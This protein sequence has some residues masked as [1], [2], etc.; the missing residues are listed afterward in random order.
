MK[1]QI[2]REQHYQNQTKRYSG[3]YQQ[4]GR[5]LTDADWNELVDILKGEVRNVLQDIIG[6]GIPAEGGARVELIS[7]SSGSVNIEIKPGKVYA[8]GW[9]AEIRNRNDPTSQ[10]KFSYAEQAD[11]LDPPSPDDSWINCVLYA[12]IWDRVV[13]SLEDPDLPDPGLNGADTCFRTQRMAQVKWFKTGQ[14]TIE[15]IPQK[16][17]AKLTL[18]LREA[19]I[20]PDPCEPCL[21]KLKI[22][23]ELGN[24][25]FRVEIASVEG[26]ADKPTAITFKWSSEN[27]AEQYLFDENHQPPAEFTSG[28]WLW[29]F[30]NKITER[31]PGVHPGNKPTAK[32]EYSP[33][34]PATPLF[35]NNHYVRR[36]DG[37]CL[38]EKN[39]SDEWVLKKDS[40][41]N[42]VIGFDKGSPLSTEAD[43]NANGYVLIDNNK[44]TI[45]INLQNIK[46]TLELGGKKVVAG[47]YWLAP[48]RWNDITSEGDNSGKL[49]LDS[50]EPQGILHHYVKLAEIN[51]VGGLVQF[52][53]AETRRNHFPALTNLMASDIGFFN[54]CK[55]SDMYHNSQNVQEALDSLCEIEAYNIKYRP[56]CHETHLNV[57]NVREA[58][59]IILCGNNE[60]SDL[61]LVGAVVPFAISSD[62]I[63]KQFER[64]EFE[65]LMGMIDDDTDKGIVAEA[66]EH[67]HIYYILRN[68]GCPHK[69]HV[70]R[71]INKY[72]Y[73]LPKGWLRCDGSEV[74]RKHFKRMFDKIGETFG[75]GNRD[76]T[77]NIPDLRRKFIRGWD[78]KSNEQWCSQHRPY[79][80][81]QLNT[82]N[83]VYSIID[84]VYC[85][86]Y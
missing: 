57:N 23:S 46:L 11:F 27:A 74:S 45:S 58:L 1:A 75:P 24:Y 25:L 6:T 28:H 81:E 37:Y 73:G 65:T 40:S 33:A 4:Q 16:G 68:I 20:V 18:Q 49:I 82:G 67:N 35:P 80:E 36:W 56:E 66:Y 9:E 32:S 41:T 44:Q 55:K 53:D 19:E 21:E 60:P 47:D 76:T 13:N 52:T 71:I 59:D 62:L 14:A 17:N 15:H 83:N 50:K 85:I 63:P 8:D 78:D 34:F 3:V 7:Y 5:M 10:R 31:L 38:I 64:E 69:L 2:S 84:L 79:S 30:Y 29:E 86:K 12:D 26:T 22:N 54:T 70:A 48:V 72:G 61:A 43:S 51:N 77:F 39:M 42:Q